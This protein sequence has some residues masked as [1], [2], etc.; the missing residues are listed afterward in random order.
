M[1]VDDMP[2]RFDDVLFLF[3]IFVPSGLTNH[4][5]QWR[6]AHCPGHHFMHDG[7]QIWCRDHN[8]SWRV[9]EEKQADDFAYAVA[10]QGCAADHTWGAAQARA[11]RGKG[12]D[13]VWP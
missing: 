10:V 11:L 1:P 7:N 12:T 2:E 5:R 8:I 13:E 6:A 9:M 4:D 3:T